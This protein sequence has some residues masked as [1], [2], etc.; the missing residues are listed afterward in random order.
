[1]NQEGGS[2]HVPK[3]GLVIVVIYIQLDVSVL[4]INLVFQSFTIINN[5]SD[6][7]ARVTPTYV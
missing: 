6:V 4:H 7:L 5:R 3:I 1:M 2:T